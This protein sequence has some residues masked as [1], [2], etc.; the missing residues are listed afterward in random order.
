VPVCC[1]SVRMRN[2]SRR[3]SNLAAIYAQ[4]RSWTLARLSFPILV[5]SPQHGLSVAYSLVMEQGARINSSS[6]KRQEE[7]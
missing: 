7:G 4:N 6:A 5:F 1:R 3:C 2:V